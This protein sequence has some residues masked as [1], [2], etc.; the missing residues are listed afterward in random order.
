MLLL[1]SNTF[2]SPSPLP[3]RTVL[4]VLSV[5]KAGHL[6][7][8]I[9]RQVAAT[10]DVAAVF[11]LGEA[12]EQEEVE[13]EARRHGDILQAGLEETYRM[14]TYKVLLGLAWAGR[15]CSEET[16]HLVKTDDNAVIDL[17]RL[18]EV[19]EGAE[20]EGRV[21]CPAVMRGVRA[22][23]H[24]RAAVLGKWAVGPAW[25][26]QVYPDHCNGWLWATGPR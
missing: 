13:E 20:V 17:R 10:R 23:R 18:E 4:L 21:V 2:H 26:R 25:P 19:L 11:L 22:W 7:N 12:E 1:L 9:R 3:P 14:T 15:W 16:R 24:P 8:R 6:R 5:P